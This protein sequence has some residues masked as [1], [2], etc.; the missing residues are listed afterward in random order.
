VIELICSDKRN[1]NLNENSNLEEFMKSKEYVV[2]KDLKE[3]GFYVTTGFKYGA[4]FLVYREDPNFIH[5][6]FM[7]F[8]Y[9][10]KKELNVN[11]L[12]NGERLG[13][14][15]KKKFLIASHDETMGTIK[16]LNFSWLNI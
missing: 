2:Y 12:I 14:S 9:D 8:I 10:S 13:V 7:L 1:L 5:S 3:K 16:Y 11:E 6:E 15:T 4:D